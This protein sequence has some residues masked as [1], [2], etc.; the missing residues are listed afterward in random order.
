VADVVL[1]NQP[2]RVLERTGC[3]YEAIAARNPRA[4]VVLVSG[5]GAT[6]PYAE[7]GGNGTLG[8]A[9]A[10]LTDQTRG[11]DGVP[12]LSGVLMGDH[13]TALAGTIGTL[14]ACYGRDARGGSGQLVDV[15]LYEAVLAV[16]A[17]QLVTWDPERPAAGREGPGIRTTFRAGDGGWV[18]VT[19]YSPAQ[20]TRLLRAVGVEV[21]DGEEDLAALV[22]QWIGGHDRATVLDAFHDARIGIAPVNDIGA[23]LADGH[24]RARDAVVE[25]D[26]PDAGMVRLPHPTPRLAATPGRVRWTARPLGADNERVYR[27]WLGLDAAAVDGL[28]RA[29]VI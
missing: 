11:P 1:L 27:E 22:G 10:G 19:A 24:A 3:T 20:I 15:A 7:R 14:A 29:E 26:D 9:F 4:V 18:A 16:L 13:L 12:R 25:V 28:R 23:L 6:G 17:P 5:W 8:E 2:R 21:G